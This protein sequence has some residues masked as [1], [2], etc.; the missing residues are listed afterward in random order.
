MPRF[1]KFSNGVHPVRRGSVIEFPDAERTH[2]IVDHFEKGL[3][4]LVTE[5]EIEPDLWFS[6]DCFSDCIFIR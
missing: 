1:L 5:G 6:P 2:V 4:A 3:T